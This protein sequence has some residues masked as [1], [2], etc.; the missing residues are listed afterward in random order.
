ML[1]RVIRKGLAV[2]RPCLATSLFHVRIHRKL[3][4]FH[5]AID[6]PAKAVRGRRAA[7]VL[8]SRA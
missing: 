1:Y 5:F 7:F 2:I 8:A 4:V 6:A 3:L